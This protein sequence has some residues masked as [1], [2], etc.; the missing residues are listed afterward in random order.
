VLLWLELRH[1]RGASASTT[2]AGELLPLSL[3]LSLSL[4]LIFD[5]VLQT[6]TKTT[7]H[8]TTVTTAAATTTTTTATPSSLDF[9]LPTVHVGQKLVLH[10]LA[11]AVLEL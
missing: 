11:P 8:A 4:S 10:V 9:V 5:S 7:T 2:T 3:S 6:P 1:P